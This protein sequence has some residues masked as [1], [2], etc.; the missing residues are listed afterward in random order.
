[1]RRSL[2]YCFHVKD[3]PFSWVT[4]AKGSLPPYSGKKAG[5]T[6]SPSERFSDLEKVLLEAGQADEARG[7]QVL[8]S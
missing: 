2:A 8:A 5:C 4:W 6:I 1:M 3:M 7:F